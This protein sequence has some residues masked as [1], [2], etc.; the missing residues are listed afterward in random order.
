[1]DDIKEFVDDRNNAWCIDCGHGQSELETNRDHVPT[2]SLLQAP[3]PPALPVIEIC[4]GCNSS[5]Q[6]KRSA[7]LRSPTRSFVEVQVPKSIQ[8]SGVREFYNITQIFE[9][10]LSERERSSVL[11]SAAGQALR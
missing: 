9:I 5:F 11:Q 8:V 7:W 4:R 6:E 1:M 10:A 2:R 3:Y